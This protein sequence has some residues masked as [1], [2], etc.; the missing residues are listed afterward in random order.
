MYTCNMKSWQLKTL[1]KSFLTNPTLSLDLVTSYLLIG[2][3]VHREVSHLNYNP[4]FQAMVWRGA[5]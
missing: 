4:T 3:Q 1:E 2:L 5:A